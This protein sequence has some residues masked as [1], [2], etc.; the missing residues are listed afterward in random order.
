MSTLY[1]AA[2]ITATRLFARLTQLG[3]TDVVVCPGSRSQALALRAAALEASGLIRL[4]VAIDERSAAFYALGIGKETGRPAAVIV[5]SGSAVGNLLPA[6]MEAHAGR[7]PLLLL[8]ADRPARLHRRRSSQTILQT[9]IFTPFLRAEQAFEVPGLA[10]PH[11][12]P[13]PD[14]DALTDAL[15]A[16]ACGGEGQEA[17][18]PVQLNLGLQEPLAAELPETV[19]AAITAAAQTMPVAAA[20][21]FEQLAGSSF[22]TSV[23]PAAPQLYSYTLDSTKRTVII[24]G[25]GATAAAEAFAHA[26]HLP[27][28]PEVVSGVRYG[29]EAIACYQRLLQ[30]A[31]TIE[32]IER[33]V[34]FGHPTLTREVARLVELTDKEIIVVDPHHGEHYGP[35]HAVQTREIHLAADYDTQAQHTWLGMWIRAARVLAAEVSTV[36]EP[37]T[38]LAREN[39][40]KERSAYARQELAAKREKITRELLV[41]SV[42]RATWPHDRLVVAASRLV[43]VLDRVA[44]PRPVQIHA[45]RGVAGI[46]GTVATARGIAAASQG[47]ES[48]AAAA[49]VT[50]VLL[51][52][53]ALLHD[54]GS[55][56]LTP[57]EPLPR[58]QLFVANDCGGTIFNG[59]E[60]R[61]IAADAAFARVMTTPHSADFAALAAAYGWEYHLL[62]TRGELEDFLT[63]PVTGPALIEVPFTA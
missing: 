15:W 52:D 19:T 7:V 42:W 26:A 23:L 13:Y 17:P 37:D 58:L 30:D 61:E 40:Y 10:D 32:M 44:Q 47:S 60:V 63:G 36:H 38:A 50:R 45:N 5:T 39:G 6:V 2:T 33:V 62:Q 18:G 9:G 57:G 14:F 54:G 34:I 12:A 51:G 25:S 48:P 49:G 53:L 59:L 1:C 56:A 31:E 35:P 28:L 29:R 8:T 46:D 24:A 21:S 11:T 4:H 20:T 16:A 43:R 22:E 41:D 3:L 55:L 27:L